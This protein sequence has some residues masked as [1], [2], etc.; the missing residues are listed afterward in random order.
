MTSAF[1]KAAPTMRP[2]RPY[3]FDYASFVVAELTPAGLLCVEWNG[4][5]LVK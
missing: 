2:G 4:V 5:V 1:W 3:G